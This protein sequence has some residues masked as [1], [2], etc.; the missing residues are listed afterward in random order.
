MASTVLD[1]STTEGSED[2]NQKVSRGGPV[3][4]APG[5][6]LVGLF[7]DMQTPHY[8][9]IFEDQTV[10]ATLVEGLFPR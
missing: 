8:I 1:K 7:L 2:T 10:M 3:C 9:D 4:L 6:C 5:I